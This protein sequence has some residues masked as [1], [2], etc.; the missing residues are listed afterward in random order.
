[1]IMLQAIILHSSGT[2]LQLLCL[3]QFASCAGAETLL[4][5][6]A[7]SPADADQEIHQRN[8]ELETVRDRLQR[9]QAQ[10]V[11]ACL[12]LLLNDVLS[13]SQLMSISGQ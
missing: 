6:I 11:I 10:V 4:A 7:Q 9:L 5:N 12:N 8:I 13:L 3:T 1:M 2:R